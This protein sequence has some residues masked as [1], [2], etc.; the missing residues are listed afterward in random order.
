MSG[1]R[2][3]K[4]SYRV[5]GGLSPHLTPDT[6]L[7]SVPTFR[8]SEETLGLSRETSRLSAPTLRSSA[9][10]S[11]LSAQHTTV[12]ARC[13][14]V[15]THLRT[16]RA[17]LGTVRV[18]LPTVRT[19]RPTVRAGI[20]AERTSPRANPSRLPTVSV[21]LAVSRRRF[22]RHR[23]LRECSGVS[24]D[25]TGASWIVDFSLPSNEQASQRITSSTEDKVERG[26][27]ERA[28]SQWPDCR[29]EERPVGRS[30]TPS[31]LSTDVER[32]NDTGARRPTPCPGGRRF[33]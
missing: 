26:M 33:V 9:H 19:H 14:T 25:G 4:P 10:G 15:R 16:N 17:R 6:F 28:R 11:R 8:L 5:D 32:G 13:V 21:L 2:T 7:L 3:T 23:A 30:L 18:Q 12:R 27:R 20:A 29:T 24:C 22:G 1:V 31:P